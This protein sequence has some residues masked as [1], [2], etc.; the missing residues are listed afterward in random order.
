MDTTGDGNSDTA[1]A[2]IPK[3][4][5]AS[6]RKDTIAVDARAK[7][8]ERISRFARLPPLPD[9]VG[10]SGPERLGLQVATCRG[11]TCYATG[12]GNEEASPFPVAEHPQRFTCEDPA[13][14]RGLGELVKG[15]RCDPKVSPLG[16]VTITPPGLRR[17][18][19]AEGRAN[20]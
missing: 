7:P 8:N 17:P 20:T 15:E 11:T 1:T 12:R 14:R 3:T 2:G 16:G 4:N 18:R 19:S 5:R 13:E 10:R 6:R 9:D